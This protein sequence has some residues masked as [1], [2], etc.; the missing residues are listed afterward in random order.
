MGGRLCSGPAHLSAG[1]DGVVSGFVD[2]TGIV[3]RAL[4]SGPQSHAAAC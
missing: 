4:A 2:Y 1:F 3:P